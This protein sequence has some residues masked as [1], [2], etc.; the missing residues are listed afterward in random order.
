MSATLSQHPLSQQGLSQPAAERLAAGPIA[1]TGGAAARAAAGPVARADGAAARA[2]R[3]PIAAGKLLWAGPL[4]VLAAVAANLLV[5]AAALAAF[6]ISPA[7]VPLN[8][9]GGGPGGAGPTIAFTAAGVGG[10][11]LLLAV[12]ARFT[13]RPVTVFRTVA[14]A[15]LLLSF[16]PDVAMLNNPAWPGATLESVGTLMAMHV[17]AGAIAIGLLTTLPRGGEREPRV[18]RIVRTPRVAAPSR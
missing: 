11:A 3:E 6:D 1:G 7:F 14:L 13:R 9:L 15:F 5:R 12:L 18:V 8:G 16:L 4:A 10:G 2:P 17:V